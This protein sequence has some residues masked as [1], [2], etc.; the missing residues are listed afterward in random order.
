MQ[1]EKE[2]GRKPSDMARHD[3]ITGAGRLPS[4]PPSVAYAPL[5][6][7]L[8]LL[9]I[10]SS[11]FS[12]QKLSPILSKPGPE[13]LWLSA[14]T[15]IAFLFICSSFLS[16]SPF[17]VLLLLL[18]QIKKSWNFLIKVLTF[19]LIHLVCA[20]FGVIRKYKLFW[21]RIIWIG[22]GRKLRRRRYIIKHSFGTVTQHW[23]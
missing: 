6:I 2:A 18:K 21:I 9:Q 4:P 23:Y 3:K 19:M 11:G 10:H 8:C 5:W 22:A 17:R 12:H 7:A 15:Y 13:A 20:A 16:L 14:T 1:A